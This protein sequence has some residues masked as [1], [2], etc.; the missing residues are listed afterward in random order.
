MANIFDFPDIAAGITH[1]AKESLNSFLESK[2]Y[3]PGKR[4]PTYLDTSIIYIL[5]FI[6][7]RKNTRV[8]G[9]SQLCL[10]REIERAVP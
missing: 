1:V 6:P 4:T 9:G 7:A 3:T 2:R 8:D 5:Y 10:R